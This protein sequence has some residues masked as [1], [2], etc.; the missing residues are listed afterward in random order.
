MSLFLFKLQKNFFFF[1]LLF[2]YKNSKNQ[3]QTNTTPAPTTQQYTKYSSAEETLKRRSH[4]KKK[5]HCT[6][7][8]RPWKK[9]PLPRRAATKE[10]KSPAPKCSNQ[11][12]SLASKHRDQRDRSLFLRGQSEWGTYHNPPKGNDS[13]KWP[14]GMSKA[15]GPPQRMKWLHQTSQPGTLSTQWP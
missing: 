13:T 8:Q 11:N 12:K 1:F 3:Q 2:L 5:V 10:E 4:Y 15:N 7:V 6:K 9:S 14:K